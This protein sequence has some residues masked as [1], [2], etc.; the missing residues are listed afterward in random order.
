VEFPVLILMPPDS[1]GTLF[2]CVLPALPGA[3][4]LPVNHATLIQFACVCRASLDQFPRMVKRIRSNAGS[5]AAGPFQYVL[6]RSPTGY[7]GK[8]H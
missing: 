1:S 3:A 7:E 6:G 4:A 5:S 2:H 8:H